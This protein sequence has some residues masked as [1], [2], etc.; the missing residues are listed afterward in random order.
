M[1]MI[2]NNLIAQIAGLNI[3]FR[4]HP[5][6]ALRYLPIVDV[7]KKDSNI[8]SI[9]EV[10]SGGLG[11]APYLKR[12]VTG[13]DTSFQPPYHPKLTKVKASVLKLPFG[14]ATYDCVVSVDMLEH[15]DSK[16]R[17]RAISEM[18]RL[19]KYKI[20]IGVPCG[21]LS[22]IQ[23]QE[24]GNYYNQI[25]NRE[26]LFFQEQV[27]YGLPDKKEILEMLQKT[28]KLYKKKIKI[29]IKGNEN[30]SIQKFL[31]KGWMTKSP[32]NNFI[33]RKLFLLLIPLFRYFDRKPYYRQIFITEVINENCN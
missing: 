23:D 12:E 25:Y 1:S 20:I 19:A 9:L 22:H 28:S 11:I 18:M 15:L 17:S 4:W 16:K 5:E 2:K 30:L 26:Y 8:S 3:F 21:K 13:V 32:I 14:D 10:G 29:I 6:V 24:L 7:I 31:M 33:F 27:N